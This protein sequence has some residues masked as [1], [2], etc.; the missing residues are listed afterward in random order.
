MLFDKANSRMLAAARMWVFALCILRVWQLP[1]V[2]LAGAPNFAPIGLLRLVPLSV[3]DVVCTVSGLYVLKVLTLA[4]LTGAL[5]GLRPYRVVALAAC[6]LLTVIHGLVESFGWISHGP[7]VLL[8]AAYLMAAFPAAD[9]WSIGSRNGDNS[10]PAVYQAAM[11]AVVLV[12]S[13]SYVFVGARRLTVGGL[14]IFTGDT[15]L[16]LV[17]LRAAELQAGGLPAYGFAVLDYPWLAAALKIGFPLVTVLELLAPLCIFHQR[18]RWLWLAAMLPFHLSVGLLMG[19]WFTE[20][21]LLMPMFLIDWPK[22]T[23]RWPSISNVFVREA[24]TLR[25]IDPGTSAAYH[26]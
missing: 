24:Q 11:I 3:W 17:I 1:L 21:M 9:A 4:L 14:E 5:L 10:K 2:D 8:F 22:L 12:M 15:I 25:R 6:A 16:H 23:A 7:L 26:S 18:F 19:I 20:N 13:L